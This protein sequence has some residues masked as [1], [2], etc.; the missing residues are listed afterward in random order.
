MN[1]TCSKCGDTV[2]FDGLTWTVAGRDSC[3]NGGVHEVDVEQHA[4][5]ADA[6][7]Q[8]GGLI[9]PE[10][11]R[12]SLGFGPSDE[13]I[14]ATQE[15]WVATPEIV[16]DT[17]GIARVSDWHQY[18]AG[19]PMTPVAEHEMLEAVSNDGN[20][21]DYLATEMM[22]GWLGQKI[23][24]VTPVTPARPYAEAL[25]ETLGRCPNASPERA[26]CE[27]LLFLARLG[28]RMST[29]LGYMEALS[30][31]PEDDIKMVVEASTYASE[32]TSLLISVVLQSVAVTKVSR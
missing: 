7:E 27:S 28:E 6:N 26:A 22:Y 23:G 9:T 29:G 1:D 19:T 25:E 24:G 21:R 16:L 31:M 10:E 14:V 13:E 20:V 3:P 17:E 30:S 15:E 4:A 2:T 18:F 12:T 11:A 32:E 5:Q 8:T